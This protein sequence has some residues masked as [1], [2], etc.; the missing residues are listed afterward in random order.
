MAGEETIK[1]FSLESNELGRNNLSKVQRLPDD[2]FIIA[3]SLCSLFIFIRAPI[4]VLRNAEFLHPG[5]PSTLCSLKPNWLLRLC[6]DI[7]P[8]HTQIFLTLSR[9]IMNFS[10]DSEL[11]CTR[12][13]EKPSHRRH[14]D[15]K[16]L[17]VHSRL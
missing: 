10:R 6:V 12:H 9:E 2:D 5:D 15:V 17:Y 7:M 3:G 14:S 4:S 1:G 11:D 8:S 16:S 13:T